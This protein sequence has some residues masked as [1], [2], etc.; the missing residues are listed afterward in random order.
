MGL[1]WVISM[2]QPDVG[3]IYGAG[4]AVLQMWVR[5]MGQVLLWGRSGSDLWG[6]CCCGADAGKIDGAGAAVGYMWVRSV[7]QVLVCCC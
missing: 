2:G 7:G 4:A 6:R 3:Q 5:S 1:L